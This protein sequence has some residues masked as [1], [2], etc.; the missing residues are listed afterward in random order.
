MLSD[1]NVLWS[2]PVQE[3]LVIGEDVW[4]LSAQGFIDRF[5]GWDRLDS[6]R[7]HSFYG[8]AKTDVPFDAH[9]LSVVQVALQILQ[10]YEVYQRISLVHHGLLDFKGIL[11][12]WLE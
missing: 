10:D 7:W 4:V 1:E 3:L 8:Y 5:L 2:E 9:L 12:P 6:M 11:H